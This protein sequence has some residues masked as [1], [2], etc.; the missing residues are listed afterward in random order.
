[1]NIHRRSGVEVCSEDEQTESKTTTLC[2]R[3]KCC[4]IVWQGV[5]EENQVELAG[6]QECEVSE[7]QCYENTN[8]FRKGLGLLKGI[9]ATVLL[10]SQSQP[11]F[12]QL[13]NVPY[14][15]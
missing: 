8:V 10:K 13:S 9:E 2:C 14:A 4:T 3:R 5:A 11:R 6:N 12:Y 1:M 7:R 15:L